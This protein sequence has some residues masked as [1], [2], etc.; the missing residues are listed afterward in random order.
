MRKLTI[1]GCKSYWQ[2]LHD[3]GED[4]LAVV[5]FPDK[6]V[7]FNRFFDRVEKFAISRC[8]KNENFLGKRILDLGCGRGRWLDYFSQRGG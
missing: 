7:W 8:I 3:K 6:P 1:E 5:T 2:N 4:D